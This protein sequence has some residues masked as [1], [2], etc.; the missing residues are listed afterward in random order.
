MALFRMINPKIRIYFLQ[1]IPCREIQRIQRT[2][3]AAERRKAV[4]RL[5]NAFV[6]GD[7][8]QA[9][10][11]CLNIE[12]RGT[13]FG[14]GVY[15]YFKVYNGKVFQAAEH[16]DRLNYSAAELE[17]R[18]PYG[19]GEISAIIETL[20]AK[21][22]VRHGGI[23]LQL[24]RGAVPRL[25]QFPA[26]CCPNFFIVARDVEPLPSALYQTGVD[27]ILLEDERWKRCDIKSLNLLANVLAKEKA[28]RA[29]YFDAILYSE[30]GITE[31]TSSSVLAV[32]DGVL[33][34]PPAGPWVLPGITRKTV[35]RLA[36]ERNI[37]V[38]ERFFS[39][40]EIFSADEVLL[41]N[42]SVDIVAVCSINGCGIGSGKPG[43]VTQSLL[44]AFRQLLVSF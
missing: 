28:K 11:A 31:S 41:T 35:L 36:T 2:I 3:V 26:N 29:G 16:L 37:P 15:E 27:A 9:E 8:L 5:I 38:A 23:Y 34:V 25:H 39:R 17:I 32:F 7:Y 33:T 12:D 19:D 4:D 40:Q 18:I 1:R 10:D 6:N 13:L 14:D 24:T 44:E 43:P 42:T 22:S 21:S 20:L 30:R